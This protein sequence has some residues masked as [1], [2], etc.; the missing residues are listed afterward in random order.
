M[1]S[2]EIVG[3]SAA[4]F[5]T[6]AFLPQAIKTIITKHTLG[7]SLGMLTLQFTGNFLWILYGFWI[8]SPSVFIANIITS[9]IVLII[10]IVAKINRR[11]E[12]KQDVAMD[13]TDLP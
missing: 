10:I 13:T 12:I 5:T 4:A 7:L 3:Y 11:K 1:Y 6:V 9:S 8:R 2:P